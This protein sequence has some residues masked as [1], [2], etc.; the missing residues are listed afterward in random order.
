VETARL[1]LHVGYGTFAEPDPADLAAG[2]LHAEWVHLP[3][4]TSQAVA[5]TKAQGGRVIAVGTTSL[6]ALEWKA[7]PGGVPQPG[8]GWC[9]LLIA[10]GHRFR[11]ADGLITNFHLPRTTLLM[12]VAA[13]AGRERVL[14]A[15]AE[16][17]ERGYRFYSYGDAMLV[18]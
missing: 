7:G 13:L 12:L 10:P 2:R 18:V 9:D 15:Y 11:A 1:T 16:A 14:A 17:M 4:A 8:E 6:W 5:R 3:P